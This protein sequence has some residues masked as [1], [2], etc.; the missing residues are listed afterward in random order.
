[1][2]FF[3]YSLMLLVRVHRKFVLVLLGTHFRVLVVFLEVPAAQ[4]IPAL[5]VEMDLGRR[6]SCPLAGRFDITGCPIHSV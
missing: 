2:I 4:Q 5:H 6:D 1:M 3:V